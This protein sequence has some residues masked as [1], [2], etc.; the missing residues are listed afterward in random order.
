MEGWVDLGYPAMHRPGVEP[1]ISRSQV[2]RP[3]HYTNRATLRNVEHGMRKQA[4]ISR[5]NLVDALQWA[6]I[7]E[8]MTDCAE[9]GLVFCGPAAIVTGHWKW[10]PVENRIQNTCTCTATVFTHIIYTGWSKKYANAF[11]S[12]I[13]NNNNNNVKDNICVLW[14]CQSHCE[15][16][17][18]SRYECRAAPGGCRPLDQADRHW[19]ISPPVGSLETTSTIANYYSARMPILILPSHGG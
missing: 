16:S 3:N 11:L 5:V 8:Q 19:A 17:S 12:I 4:D 1:A 18:D 9:P 13:D 10:P 15:I 14:P 6:V 2:Q 7:T